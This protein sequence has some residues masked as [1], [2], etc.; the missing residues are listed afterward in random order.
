VISRAAHREIRELPAAAS[1]FD[2]HFVARRGAAPI[3]GP[4]CTD[5]AKHCNLAIELAA[6]IGVSAE[7]QVA[8]ELSEVALA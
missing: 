3:D 6:S 8:V 5:S 4:G 1:P 7:T 2:A